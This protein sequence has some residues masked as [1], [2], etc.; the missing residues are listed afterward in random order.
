MDDDKEVMDSYR[1]E[2]INEWSLASSRRS[3]SSL[4]IAW[5]P[6]GESAMVWSNMEE[7]WKW[8]EETAK[9][10]EKEDYEVD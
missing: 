4:G 10:V 8:L 2:S 7:M 5:R 6:M 9:V 3:L 1:T